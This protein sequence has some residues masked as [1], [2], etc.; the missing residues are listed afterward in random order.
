M[1]QLWNFAIYKLLALLQKTICVM[2][3]FFVFIHSF[4]L[5]LCAVGQKITTRNLIVVEICV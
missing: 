3:F 4:I 5:R 2:C 1:V